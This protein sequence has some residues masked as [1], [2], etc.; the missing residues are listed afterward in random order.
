MNGTINPNGVSAGSFFEWGTSATLNTSTAT[1]GLGSSTGTCDVS[2]NSSVFSLSN[3][4]GELGLP[5]KCKDEQHGGLSTLASLGPDAPRGA[6]LTGNEG[7]VLFAIDLPGD[8][9][10]HTSLA[11]QNL[12][13]LFAFVGA[14]RR[15]TPVIGRLEDEVPTG[16][17]GATADASAAIASPDQHVFHRIPG[18]QAAA[19]TVRRRWADGRRDQAREGTLGN[20]RPNLRRTH[21]QP[22]KPFGRNQVRFGDS[23]KFIVFPAES[24]VRYK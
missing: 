14:P 9:R 4:R 19:H 10:R 8:R 24:M 6:D 11:G 16:G 18:L 13:Q 3:R 20:S 23:M 12:V 2:V 7:H 1:L 15:E 5:V 22:E 17:H 21:G